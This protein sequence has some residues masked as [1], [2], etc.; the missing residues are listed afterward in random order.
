MSRLELSTPGEIGTESCLY[1]VAIIES[2]CGGRVA[3]EK[4]SKVG[5]RGTVAEVAYEKASDSVL[6]RGSAASAAAT[7]DDVFSGFILTD[8]NGDDCIQAA[9]LA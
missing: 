8:A 5:C 1:P 4:P 9:L 7:S 3:T 6:G 2:A